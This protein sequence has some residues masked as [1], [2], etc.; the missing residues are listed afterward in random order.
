VARTT[1]GARGAVARVAKL[2]RSEIGARP[3]RSQSVG[4]PYYRLPLTT[5][6]RESRRPMSASTA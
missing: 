5:P 6:A 3:L 1:K 4:L 2:M